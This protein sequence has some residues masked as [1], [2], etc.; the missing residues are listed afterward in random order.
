[1]EIA[2]LLEWTK[3][4]SPRYKNIRVPT[5]VITG[6][7]DSIVSPVLHSEHLAR[8]IKSARLIVV[9]NLGH[10]SDYVANDLAIAAIETVAGKKPDLRQITKAIESRIAADP[11]D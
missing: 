6:D 11:A 7:T 3:I 4:N 5:V 2:N 10:K 9:H 1:M 8:D